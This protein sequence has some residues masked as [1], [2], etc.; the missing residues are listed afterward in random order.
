MTP[1]P[2]IALRPTTRDDLDTLFRIQADPAGNA[3]AGTKPRT[4]DAY[5]AVWDTI[6]TD[7]AV[8]P[9]SILADGLLVGSINQFRMEN[10]NA[11]GYWIDRAWWGRGVASRA[12]ALF[13]AEVPTRPLHA[14][15]ALDNAASRRILE[16][17][18]FALTHTYEG[19]ETDRY[20]ARTVAAYVL[21]PDEP[22]A[23]VSGSCKPMA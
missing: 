11:V 23:S 16:K 2:S 4:R 6:L 10:A 14:T 15:V 9:R 20:T 12:L 18:G 5:F 3:L 22:R 17:H 21:R 8:I 1:T 13:L 19:Q 7:P